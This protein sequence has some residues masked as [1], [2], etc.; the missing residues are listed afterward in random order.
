[1]FATIETVNYLR[2]CSRGRGPLLQRTKQLIL[3]KTTEQHIKTLGFTTQP[4][5]VHGYPADAALSSICS[6]P[7]S[8]CS[9][10]S[11]AMP[12]EPASV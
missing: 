5:A 3:S 11:I 7:A 9:A 6:I 1:M 8:A 12:V 10:F 4:N 2:F